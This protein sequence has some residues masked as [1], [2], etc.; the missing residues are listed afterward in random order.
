[1]D[2]LEKETIIKVL[3]EILEKVEYCFDK[4]TNKYYHREIEGSLQVYFN[5]FQSAQ[6]C[7]FL[8]YLSNTIYPYSSFLADKIYY[9]NKALNACDFYHQVQ[10]PKFF[11]LN[12]P[13]G[14]VMGRAKYSDGFSFGQNCTVGN[15]NNVYPTIGENLRICISSAILG[16]SHIGNNVTIGA[17]AIVKDQ[18]IPDNSIVFGQSPNLIIEPKKG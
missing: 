2:D 17:G 8:Y 11:S 15:N 3:L 12:H 6:C 9:L 7:I 5:S 4:Q 18:D 16:N 1:M 14:A 10:L 13:V